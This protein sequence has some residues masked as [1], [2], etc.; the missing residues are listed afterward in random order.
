MVLGVVED[1]LDGAVDGGVASSVR[2]AIQ[3][4]RDL[5]ARTVPVRLGGLDAA[6]AAYYVL[7]TSEAS[8]NLA[9]Y[10]GVRYG[11]RAEGAQTAREVYTRTRAESLGDEVQRRIL[12]GT[13]ALSSGYYDAYYDKAQRVREHI[14][15]RFS[16]VF[17]Q[18]VDALVSPVAPTTAFRLG[19]NT[20]DQ[21]KMYANDVMNVPASL[22][23]L[24]AISVPCGTSDNMPV[25][26][27][28]IA[29]YLP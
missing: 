15:R 7:A 21:T 22:A 23:G 18:G 6:T 12:L 4:L 25:A 9:R 28:V 29:P 19:E 14:S 13:F 17:A 16:D 20:V 27:Q 5:G 24:P 8:A 11:T 10:D 1:A 26:L 3:R 2:D